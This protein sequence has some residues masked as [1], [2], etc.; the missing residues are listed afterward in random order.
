[1]IQLFETTH[2]TGE[3]LQLNFEEKGHY[4]TIMKG[5]YADAS[6][7]KEL[8]RAAHFDTAL[9]AYCLHLASWGWELEGGISSCAPKA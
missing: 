8:T 9:W 5:T 6:S 1:M 7:W 4:F 3:A 2:S